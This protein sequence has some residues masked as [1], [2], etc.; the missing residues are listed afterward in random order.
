MAWRSATAS[1][2][3]LSR[4]RRTSLRIPARSFAFVFPDSPGDRWGQIRDGLG[5]RLRPEADTARVLHGLPRMSGPPS[6]LTP[7]KA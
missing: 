7:R 1:A 5:P 6:W 2:R 3:C 4:A